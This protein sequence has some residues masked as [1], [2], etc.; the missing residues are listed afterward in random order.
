MIDQIFPEPD[1]KLQELLTLAYT[2]HETEGE[3]SSE[4]I[5]QLS[6][7]EKKELAGAVTAYALWQQNAEAKLRAKKA[8]LE[9]VIEQMENEIKYH[10][11]KVRFIEWRIMQLL[12]PSGQSSL[13]NDKVDVFYSKSE[14]LVIPNQES[15]P[16]EYC[17]VEYRPLT[18]EIKAAIKTGAPIDFAEIKTNW[19]L[20]IKPGGDKAIVN[21]QKR[22]KK[23]EQET[24]EQSFE[25]PED[26]L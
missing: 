3:V 4:I 6:K 11:N 21:A 16:I 10:A 26:I 1:K 25:V 14:S 12:T 17:K 9:P 22:A 18:A 13:T 24:T 2:E 8:E 20:Q 15:V 7:L 19:N 5:Q 23:R